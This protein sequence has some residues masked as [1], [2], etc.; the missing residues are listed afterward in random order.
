M[1]SAPAVVLVRRVTEP[2]FGVLELWRG[3]DLEWRGRIKLPDGEEASIIIPI[4]DEAY[5][6]DTLGFLTPA[7][8]ATFRRLV[9]DEV[10]VRRAVCKR[11][12]EMAQDW[13]ASAELPEL[14]AESFAGSLR[15]ESYYIYADKEGV[16][17]EI[18]FEDSMDIFAGHVFC[19]TYDAEGKLQD[20]ALMG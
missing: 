7:A 14:D 15:T 3:H 4:N 12:L 8:R 9:D 13:A 19:A 17:I 11:E 18:W 2:D 16:S 10:K 6:D 5:A 20:V 1:Q